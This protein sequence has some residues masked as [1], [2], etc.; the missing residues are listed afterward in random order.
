MPIKMYLT[1]FSDFH[2]S[3]FI[4]FK[5][6]RAALLQRL[7]T[8]IERLLI[9]YHMLCGIDIWY[10]GINEYEYRSSI[11]GPIPAHP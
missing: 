4:I 7:S 6:I 11:S 10:R 9:I 8:V 2:C 3:F 5:S 1:S